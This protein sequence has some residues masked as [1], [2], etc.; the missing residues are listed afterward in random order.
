MKLQHLA[1]IFVII[2][3]PISMIMASYIQ[4][5]IDA[6]TLQTK[7]DSS[8]ISATYDAVQAFQLNTT[9]NKYS[10]ISDS[11]IRDIEAAISTFYNSLNTSMADYSASASDLEAYTPAI[12]FTLY[13]GYYIYST[14]DNVY[15][16]T[17][18]DEDEKVDITL[19]GRNYQKGLRPYVYYSAKYQLQ[20][21]NIIVVNYTLDNAITVYGDFGGSEGY[22]TKSGYFI[23]PDYV[24]N[25]DDN[26]KTLTYDGVTIEPEIL[27]EHLITIEDQE[28]GTAREDDYR[29]IFYQNEK[30]YQDQDENGNL[31]Y[32][33]AAGNVTT[34]RNITGI[35]VIFWFDNYIKTY[36]NDASIRQ[37]AHDCNMM[38]TSAF[39][40][41][42]EAKEF[43]EW[44][45]NHLGNITQSNTL[46]IEDGTT[47]I[48]ND[49]SYLAENTGDQRIFLAS[50]TNDPM[51]AESAFNN[52]RLAIIRK[53]IETNMNTVISN[54]RTTTLYDYAMP[55]MTDNDWYKILNNVSMVTF[56]Q[57]MTIGFRYY[58]NYAIITNNVNKEVIKPENIYIIAEDSNENREYHQPGCKDLIEGL[59]NGTLTLVTESTS[60]S[61]SYTASAYPTASF[62]RQSIRMSENSEDDLNYYL[63]ARGR[64]IVGST[65]TGQ[66]TLTGCYNCIVN[67]T[68]DYD[69]DDIT[70]GNDLIDYPDRVENGGTGTI[71][72][73]SNNAAYQ[74]VRKAYLTALARERQD[75]YKSNFDLSI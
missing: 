8:L 53:S 9:N 40:Y 61:G 26:A 28:L 17:G 72:F 34:D 65:I 1:I 67:A 64:G 44:V 54:Y 4:N 19:D 27:T 5:Q 6:I 55:V 3:L 15:G 12:L 52:H 43:S 74:A 70:G 33:D 37:Y 13:D 56:L 29:Y 62:Q 30:V 36:V 35:P 71:A 11:K 24:Q 50:D 45:I 48:G 49:T 16:T 32:Y 60:A 25:I 2:I 39:D 59:Q 42:K 41:Y 10:S 47:P 73:R 7:Y 21:G 14:Y 68:A 31:L 66:K 69:I 75:L 51:L 58:N 18:E 63:Q 22:V 46:K 38:S 20:N 57:G 23:N